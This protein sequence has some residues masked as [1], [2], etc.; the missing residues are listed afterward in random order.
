MTPSFFYQLF[1]PLSFMLSMINHC[2]GFKHLIKQA[3]AILEILILFDLTIA[4]NEGRYG[5]IDWG[6]HF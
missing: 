5:Q 1:N 2:P 3:I 6:R 4:Q